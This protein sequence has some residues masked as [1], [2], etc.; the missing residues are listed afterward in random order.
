MRCLIPTLF[1]LFSVQVIAE[2]IQLPTKPA[3]DNFSNVLEKLERIENKLNSNE[4]N[5]EEVRTLS[6]KNMS[7]TIEMFNRFSIF[8]DRFNDLINAEAEK[9]ARTNDVLIR[10]NLALTQ[11]FEAIEKKVS[12][13]EVNTKI[14][15]SQIS[16]IEKSSKENKLKFSN[17]VVAVSKEIETRTFAVVLCII[18]ILLGLLWLRYRLMQNKTAF[19]DEIIKARTALDSEY[20]SLDLKLTELLEKQI[21]TAGS[22]SAKSDETSEIDKDHSLPLKVAVEIHRMRKRIVSMPADIKGIKPLIKALERLE[23]S[24]T[25]QDYEVVEL[26]GQKYVDGMTINLDFKFDE[27]L[28]IDDKLI[29]SVTKPQVNYRG[30]I[31][32]VAD[33]IVSTGEEI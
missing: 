1:I 31:I 24:L 20:N 32:Q 3:N 21:E 30:V 29:S 22:V 27:D 33:V 16:Q 5:N 6:E 12:T 25:E 2:E 14:I 18:A 11:N 7:D 15:N 26:L 28:S 19:S 10:D 23:E 9:S 17:N 4:I 8:E 13:T